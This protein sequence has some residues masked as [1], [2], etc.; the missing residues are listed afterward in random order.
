MQGQPVVPE[1]VQELLR[2]KSPESPICLVGASNNPEKY[3]NRIMRNLLSKGY[4]V[5]PVNPRETTIEGQTAYASVEDVPG[6]ISILNFVVPPA[7][8][9]SVLRKAIGREVDC[10]WFQ[11]GSYD[12]ETIALAQ[13]HFVH[14]VY[15]ACIMVV[16]GYGPVPK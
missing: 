15:G 10:L 6:H 13:A 7:V 11:D 3:G 4:T 2:R 12:D 1:A 5:L 9:R 8:T 16:T 14:V